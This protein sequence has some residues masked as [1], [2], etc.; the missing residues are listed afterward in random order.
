MKLIVIA[1]ATV[2]GNVLGMNNE[3]PWRLKEDLRRFRQATKGHAVIMGRKTRESLPGNEPLHDRYNIVLTGKYQ[4]GLGDAVV[5]SVGQ[6]II[7]AYEAGYERVFIIGG[8]QLYKATLPICDEALI[9]LVHA[10]ELE[11]DAYLDP[12]PLSDMALASSEKF[13]RNLDN[14]Y[15]MTF[16]R[17]IR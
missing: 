9:T 4:P 7:A 12:G 5:T 17:W 8:A 2:P 11:G 15:D 14:E 16:Q 1:A 10:P 3:L 13:G 6:A